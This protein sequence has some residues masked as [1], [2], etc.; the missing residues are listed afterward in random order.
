MLALG[1][2]AGA[3]VALGIVAGAMVGDL[4][5]LLWRVAPSIPRMAT[6]VAFWAAQAGLLATTCWRAARWDRVPPAVV[7]VSGVLLVGSV[8]VG[9]VSVGVSAPRG[10]FHGGLFGSAIF[11]VWA[12]MFCAVGAWYGA[13][14]TGEQPLGR[15]RHRPALGGGLHA[16]GWIAL[17]EVAHAGLTELQRSVWHAL[18]PAIPFGTAALPFWVAHGALVGAAGWTARRF[19]GAPPG[20]VAA[21]ALV[22]MTAIRVGVVG[23]ALFVVPGPAPAAVLSVGLSAAALTLCSLAGACYAQR[24]GPAARR[25]ASEIADSSPSAR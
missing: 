8:A 5:S 25:G 11:T 15:Q 1:I 10:W 14:C 9:D 24:N 19:D 20:V 16:A 18:S 2:R 12:T 13:Q 23:L 21:A 6:V 17:A 22:L 7:A 3:W 4:A